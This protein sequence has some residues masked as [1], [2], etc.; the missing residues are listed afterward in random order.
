MTD[1][2]QRV[3]KTVWLGAVVI[4][5]IMLAC[6]IWRPHG[7]RVPEELL[8]EWRTTDPNYSGRAL[9]IDEVTINFVTGDG[10]LS[11]GFITGVRSAPEGNRTLYTI[12][13]SLDGAPN[14]VSFF[15]EGARDKTIKFKNQE[16]TI[17]TKQ[18]SS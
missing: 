3:W 4:G 5:A 18:S 16:T 8:G 2:A 11:V 15:C 9:K 14:E 7:T 13:Y 6:W 1:E 12:S 10:Q 17:W